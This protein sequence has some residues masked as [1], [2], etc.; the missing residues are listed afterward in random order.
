[1]K[2]L[3][4]K[5]LKRK[6]IDRVINMEQASTL[7][8]LEYFMEEWEFPLLV[9]GYLFTSDG[10]YQLYLDTVEKSE[11]PSPRIK[12]TFKT[13]EASKTVEIYKSVFVY[14]DEVVLHIERGVPVTMIS[15]ERYTLSFTFEAYSE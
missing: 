15:S 7:Q 11:E 2:A 5:R 13:L 14:D 3:D 6:E 8:K 1:M 4:S 10:V 9:G 12:Y